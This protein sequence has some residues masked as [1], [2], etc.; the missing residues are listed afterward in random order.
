MSVPCLLGGCR[1]LRNQAELC[2]QLHSCTHPQAGQT[3][4]T[5]WL[6]F[7][8]ATKT[9]TKSRTAEVK[10]G[11]YTCPA[12]AASCVQRPSCATQS[13]TQPPVL[14]V[15]EGRNGQFP[16]GCRPVG[17]ALTGMRV[18]QREDRCGQIDINGQRPRVAR[19]SSGSS[20]DLQRTWHVAWAHRHGGFCGPPVQ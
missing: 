4:I 12:P 5:T 2:L 10:C 13:A 16:M 19:S 1:P 14:R 3:V 8:S 6:L 7:Q 20:T 18:V 15:P 11:L 17:G 9:N